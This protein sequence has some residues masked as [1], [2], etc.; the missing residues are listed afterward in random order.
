M[1]DVAGADKLRGIRS[2]LFMTCVSVINPE[3]IRPA[4]DLI[5]STL[6][7]VSYYD[8]YEGEVSRTQFKYSVAVDCEFWDSQG[9]GDED[10]CLVS[11]MTVCVDKILAV[12]FHIY[13]MITSE[14]NLAGA[15]AVVLGV[16]C[17]R[18]LVLKTENLKLTLKSCV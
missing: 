14:R 3:H 4:V 2:A 11:C 6:D 18:Y 7:R 1:P 17:A 13:H 12:N 10:R 9:P 16:Y 8:K 5:R 15:S